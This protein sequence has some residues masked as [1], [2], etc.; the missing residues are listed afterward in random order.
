MVYIEDTFRLNQFG[1][2]TLSFHEDGSFFVYNDANLDVE[3]LMIIKSLDSN[4]TSNVCHVN[5]IKNFN[6][7]HFSYKITCISKNHPGISVEIYDMS[8]N[9]LFKRNYHKTKNYRCLNL[10]SDPWDCSYSPYQTF[11]NDEYFLSKFSIKDDD[12]V[13]DLGANVGA[14]S[15]ACSNYDIKK[16]YAFEPVEFTFNYLKYNCEKYGKNVTCFNK[17]IT[18]DFD[19]LIM[20]GDS[21]VDFS[22]T[23]LNLSTRITCQTINLEKFVH[24]NNLEL[25]TYLKVDIEGSEYIFFENTSDDFFKNVHSIFFEFHFNDGNNVQKIIDRFKNLGYKLICNDNVLNHHMG[26]V[27]FIK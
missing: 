2:I 17:A 7:W 9:L 4:L 26:T 19:K 11:F 14:F 13:Y 27:Y 23:N 1:D 25:P 10:N 20:S 12:I 24:L 21:S 6:V 3:F 22:L 15:L 18:K 8:K 16:I 5:C